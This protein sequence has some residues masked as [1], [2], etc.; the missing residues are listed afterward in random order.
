[1]HFLSCR[2]SWKQCIG[3]N[4]SRLW[5]FIGDERRGL[6]LPRK[7]V[8]GESTLPDEQLGLISQ[9]PCDWAFLWRSLKAIIAL[10]WVDMLLFPTLGCFLP[11]WLSA[12]ASARFPPRLSES[13]KAVCGTRCW[14][15]CGTWSRWWP[16]DYEVWNPICLCVCLTSFSLG[17]HSLLL[18]NSWAGSVETYLLILMCGVNSK[19]KFLL[20]SRIVVPEGYFSFMAHQVQPPPS[21]K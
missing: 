11:V 1:M 5:G 15:V 10:H 12:R 2:K 13:I 20:I 3:D 18:W 7:P 8:R 14:G 6:S 9:L 19:D 4:Q 17:T 21:Q 16:G